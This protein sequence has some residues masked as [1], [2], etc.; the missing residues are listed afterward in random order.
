MTLPIE[1][2]RS[3]KPVTWLTVLGV[4]LLPAVLGGILVSA[5]YN[6]TERLDAMT[7]AIV[8]EDEAVEIDGQ[9]TPL[10]RQLSAGLVEGSDDVGSNLTWVLSN[11]DDAAEGLEDGAY[12]AV[13]T[14]P[15]NFSA[16]ATSSGQ[17]LAATGAD[18]ASV[19]AQRAVIEVATPSDA[20][21]VDDAITAQITQTAAAVL[22]EQL[23]SLTLENVFLGFTTIGDQLGEAALGASQLAKGTE[24]AA[25]GAAEL[26]GGVAQLGEGASGLASGAGSL[27]GGL[28]T[29][30]DETRGAGDGARQIADGA[31]AGAA[32]LE[33]QGLVPQQLID[34]TTE[35]EQGALGAAQAAGGAAT[36]VTG[37]VARCENPV[38]DP[39]FCTELAQ[40]AQQTE[41]ASQAVGAVATGASSTRIGLEQFDAGATSQIAGQFRQLGSGVGQLA[42]G[43][44]Q[45]AGGVDQSASGAAQLQSGANQ[46]AGGLAELQTGTEGLATGLREL[47]G[48]SRELADGLAEA[49]AS[50][51]SY[52]DTE[53]QNLAEVVSDPV[54]A[55]GV[56][57]SLFGASAIP[58]LSMLVLWF[59]ALATFVA[60]GA[61]T[62]RALAARR[63]SAVL[64]LRSFAPAALIGAVQGVLVA[65][66]VQLAATYT[67]GEW[68]GFAAV[69]VLA[70]VAFAA[71]NQALVAVFGGAGRWIAALVG[72]LAMATGVVSTV[73]GVLATVAG[74]MPTS[75][76]Y[77]A[78]LGALAGIEGVGAGV[79]ALLIWSLLAL[80]ATTLAVARRRTTSARAALAASA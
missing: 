33:A 24:E 38:D 26:P 62:T 42:D 27:A 10:G 8:N 5:L 55:D 52:T 25:A 61:L 63:P 79:A 56:G 1:R 29:I 3:R 36:T 57:T 30:A 50:L 21:I 39:D 45:L 54:A 18:A 28:G 16:A 7:A 74:L 59:G 17:S 46:L 80:V 13:V 22:G 77:H 2:A 78:M 6:P 48:G 34:G 32:Q 76:A 58:L 19:T 73:P 23:S 67:W 41:I 12:Q 66:V 47:A 49:S 20:L 71:V 14:I 75:P 72:V 31:N 69:A 60:L 68:F 11:A 53:A 40:A 4:L 65:A 37:L 35:L 64:A 70:G 15:A 43:L 44:D 9:L 51:P